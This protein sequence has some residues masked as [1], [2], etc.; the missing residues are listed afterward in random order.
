MTNCT[1]THHP[2]HAHQ[3]GPTCEHQ[4]IR[5]NGHIDYLHDGHL[6][7]MHMDH[8]DEHVIAVNA[9]NPVACTP[10]IKCASHTHGSG[11][12]HETIPHGDHLDYLVDGDLHHPHGDHCDMHGS[13]QLVRVG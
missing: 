10:A 11:C 7:H 5:H 2:D 4:A 3:H 9:A 1:E 8:T 6:H 12:G 13:V